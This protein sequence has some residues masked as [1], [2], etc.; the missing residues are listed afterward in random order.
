MK[1]TRND[2]R[3]RRHRRVR[4]KVLGTSERPRLAV[5]RSHK[6]I[7]VQ[8]IDDSQQHTLV[9]ASTLDPEIT[10]DLKT[11]ATCDASVKVGQ[12][13]AQRSLSKGIERVVFD[14][15]GYIYHGRVKALADAAREA[16]LEF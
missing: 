16:G 5:F 11:G 6:H 8:V 15:G 13:I 10:A 14:R 7:Y 4:R 1:L 2:S 3:Q 9:A 12:L